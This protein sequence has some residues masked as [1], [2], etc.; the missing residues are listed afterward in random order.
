MITP[1]DE[2]YS[3]AQAA[4]LLDMSERQCARHL[5]AGLIKAHR[6]NGRWRVTA[7]ALWKYLGIE[8]EMLRLWLD[9]CSQNPGATIADSRDVTTVDAEKEPQATSGT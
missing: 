6:P 7:L 8:Q 9:Y 1:P 3:T 5:K 4:R 2:T